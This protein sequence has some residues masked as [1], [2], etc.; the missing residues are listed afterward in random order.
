MVRFALAAVLLSASVA[1]AEVKTKKVEYKHGETTFVG[2]LAW[3][4]AVTGKRPGV[5]VVHEWWGLNAHAKERAEGLAKLGYVALAC[6]MYGNGKTAA[7]PD[8][9]RKMSG[10]VRKSVREWQARAAA[11][12]KVLTESEFCDADRLGAM[13]FCFGGSTAL[14]L[15][16][17]GAKLKAI[18]TFH[19]ALPQFKTE[20][21]AK[22]AAKVLICHGKEDFFIKPEDITN[23]RKAMDEGKV[24]Y[25]FEEYPGAFHSFT[26][27]DADAAKIKGM[28]YNKDADEKSWASMTKLLEEAFK[29]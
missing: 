5:L 24:S 19:A 1:S 6:D 4:D 29:K 23:F 7:H 8:D 15:G 26:A 12:L 10:E 25:T 9:A 22:I 2:H 14:Q 16:A 17:S 28:A 13:G 11:A 3:D 18:V 27:K 20:E 21:A